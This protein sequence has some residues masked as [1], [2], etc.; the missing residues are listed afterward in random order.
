M[1]GKV[2]IILLSIIAAVILAS[3]GY[4][5]WEDRL[6]INSSIQ[7]E[8]LPAPPTPSPSP[9]LDNPLEKPEKEKTNTEQAVSDT[10]QDAALV[11][12]E[13]TLNESDSLEEDD[14]LGDSTSN[15]TDLSDEDSPNIKVEAEAS[16]PTEALSDEKKP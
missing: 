12:E 15:L 10:E 9:A 8:R 7:I 1:K 6:V 5:L 14:K 16:N 4:G 3:G 2:F 13:T 11:D